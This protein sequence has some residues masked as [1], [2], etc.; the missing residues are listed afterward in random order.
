MKL[1]EVCFIYIVK[2]PI[3]CHNKYIAAKHRQNFMKQ[4]TTLQASIYLSM[5][6]HV[7]KNEQD[8]T[9]PY[10]WASHCYYTHG[11]KKGES[12]KTEGREGVDG[13]EEGRKSNGS[14][15]SM[16]GKRRRTEPKD[17][18]DNQAGYYYGDR[19]RLGEISGWNRKV[20]LVDPIDFH[21][22]DLCTPISID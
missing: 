11:C 18:P 16:T 4:E 20:G 3:S 5:S 10:Y 7:S 22:R 13:T 14:L 12:L 19:T 8:M 15:E 9:F 2:T 6:C 21:V 17:H 1:F